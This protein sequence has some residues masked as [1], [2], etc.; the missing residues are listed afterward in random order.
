MVQRD[1]IAK[2][3]S[4]LLEFVGNGCQ[5]AFSRAKKEA[6]ISRCQFRFSRIF[7]APIIWCES[8]RRIHDIKRYFNG[9]R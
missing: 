3:L 8:N 1:V 6:D 4:G 7:D 5:R 2:D 9:N